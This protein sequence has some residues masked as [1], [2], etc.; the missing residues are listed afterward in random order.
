M[1]QKFKYG[2]KNLASLIFNLLLSPSNISMHFLL[3]ILSTT[4]HVHLRPLCKVG[5][6]RPQYYLAQVDS[7]QD[8][9]FYFRFENFN[10]QERNKNSNWAVSGLS[11]RAIGPTPAPKCHLRR[12]LFLSLLLN[13][14]IET[15]TQ[16]LKQ[17]YNLKIKLIQQ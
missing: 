4:F 5:R 7:F 6:Y 3:S 17:I 9:F 10:L 8:L 12:K 14:F 13:F 2:S 16:I 11:P 1:K 15:K